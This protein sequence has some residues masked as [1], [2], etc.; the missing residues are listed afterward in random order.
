MP[1]DPRLDAARGLALFMI[2]LTHMPGHSWA[3][4]TL[5]SYGFSDAAEAFV[6]LAGIAA[7][8]AYGRPGIPM[9]WIA[10]TRR[11]MTLAG[12]HLLLTF[13]A[14]S[15]ALAAALLGADSLIQK[16]GMAPLAEGSKAHWI[17]VFLGSHQIG[18]VNILTLYVVLIALVPAFFWGFRYSLRGTLCVSAAVWACAGMWNITLMNWPSEGSWQFNPFAW[19][20]LFAIGLAFGWAAANHRRIELPPWT[21]IAAGGIL[22]G[23]FIW[24]Q[25]P[26]VGEAGRAFLAPFWDSSLGAHVLGFHKPDLGGM[27][28]LHALALGCVVAGIPAL[29]RLAASALMAPLRV[30][31][32]HGL[33]LFCL[34]TL[35]S[36]TG[37][38]ILLDGTAFPGRDALM[39]I[40]AFLALWGTATALDL[41]RAGRKRQLARAHPK[42]AIRA[43]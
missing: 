13:G 34:G 21:V 20:F 10:T 37:Q 33:P 29:A 5:R 40:F 19:Q 43:S 9:P 32:R 6:L 27:R 3:H 42:T 28:L 23:A 18:Y 11:S 16:H 31:G 4:W 12:A 2:V 22:V 35:I 8:L 39:A 30:I 14:L 1:R 17:G 26:D 36:F 38:A 7:G 25:S 41:Q 15:V 24:R